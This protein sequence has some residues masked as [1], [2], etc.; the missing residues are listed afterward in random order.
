MFGIIISDNFICYRPVLRSF[1]RTLPLSLVEPAAAGVGIGFACAILFF[2]H[3]TS[4]LILEGVEDVIDLLKIPLPLSFASR[5]GLAK[6]DVE[7]VGLGA[8][9]FGPSP[10]EDDG[11]GPKDAMCGII[12]GMLEGS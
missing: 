8:R 9:E 3:S 10:V 11:R 2:P 1:N 5:N 6:T 12:K 7:A 4:D